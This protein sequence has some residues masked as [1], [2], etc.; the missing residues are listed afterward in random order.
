MPYARKTEVQD[1]INLLDSYEDGLIN[2]VQ[3]SIFSLYK[4]I[5]FY[6]DPTKFHIKVASHKNYNLYLE[7][8]SKQYNNLNRLSITM[9]TYKK[10]VD[11]FNKLDSYIN[12]IFAL[13]A[14]YT[15]KRIVWRYYSEFLKTKELVGF[16]GSEL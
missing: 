8:I 14:K 7:E 16:S 11:R 5:H 2:G 3:H 1:L 6:D 4:G 10:Y 13:Y 15:E 12:Y 9:Q